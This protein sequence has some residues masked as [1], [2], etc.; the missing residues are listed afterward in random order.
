LL[1][2]Y[3]CKVQ[4]VFFAYDP[5]ASLADCLQNGK[6]NGDKLT[7]AS[8][9]FEYRFEKNLLPPCQLAQDGDYLFVDGIIAFVLYFCKKLFLAFNGFAALR[10]TMLRKA[11]CNSETA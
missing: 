9:P 8:N 5:H 10:S 6:E 3:Q 4:P 1:Y 11:S 2:F 7:S